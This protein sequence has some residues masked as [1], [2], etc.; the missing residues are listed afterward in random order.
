VARAEVRSLE[1]LNLAGVWN[2]Y[3]IM[4]LEIA[5]QHTEIP[6]QLVTPWSK[7]LAE[8]MHMAEM[9]QAAELTQLARQICVHN[10]PVNAMRTLAH[11]SNLPSQRQ[12]I[13]S[14]ERCVKALLYIVRHDCEYSN[15][16]TAG[17]AAMAAVNILGRNERGMILGKEAVDQVLRT[18]RSHFDPASRRSK[19]PW[20]ACIPN[21]KP[22]NHLIVA[23]INKTF[24]V[25][26][27]GAIDSLVGCCWTC[28]TL[29]AP[30]KEPRS[31]SRCARWCCRIWR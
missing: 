30:K 12:V 24:V 13:A 22:L 14:D 1:T 25:Q 29:G 17:Y 10:A 7:V 9:I 23:D 27:A 21:V 5:G 11:S 31:C 28:P 16:S 4:G 20:R 2:Y 6:P 8:A 26:H 15:R 18:F 19:Y 3:T